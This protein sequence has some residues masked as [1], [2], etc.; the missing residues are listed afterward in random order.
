V[1][2]LKFDY[3]I[4]SEMPP[5]PETP[6]QL[7]SRF[8]HT[9]D[10]LTRID[11]AIFTNW[12]VMDY[13]AR[14]SLP[15]S[16]ARSHIAAIIEKNVYRNDLREPLPQYGYTAGAL[17]ITDDKSRRV[18]LRIKTGG[19]K[20][21]ETSLRTGEWSVLPD[22]AMVTYPIY[23]AALLA[24][25][26]NWPP[27]WACAY[28]FRLD[29]Q[30][31]ALVLGAALFPYSLFHITWIAYLSAPLAGELELPPEISTE[32]TPD[33]GLLM[34]ATKERLDPTDPEHLRRARILAETMMQRTGER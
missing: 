25:G 34:S 12:E 14:D 31:E 21:G 9:L 24:I 26:A 2:E 15:L 17:I 20:K 7:G 30:K 22:P 3:Y 33:G 11:P 27:R 13:R 32:R 4:R 29:Y 1:N 6:A 19:T 10:A 5:R 18:G 16:E 28:A 23:K 8:V